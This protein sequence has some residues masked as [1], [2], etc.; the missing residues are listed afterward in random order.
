MSE[1]KRKVSLAAV[2]RDA[3]EIIWNYR[4]RLGLGLLLLIVGRLAGMILPASIKLLID[5]VI[6]KGR[7]EILVWIAVAAG[8]GALVQAGSSFSLALLLSA[9]CRSSSSTTTRAAR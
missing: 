5:D 6:G 3:R 4:K 2:T 1:K 7:T 8:L 9:A